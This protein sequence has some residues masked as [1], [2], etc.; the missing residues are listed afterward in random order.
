MFANLENSGIINAMASSISFDGSAA[1][2][3]S[4]DLIYDIS[5]IFINDYL[6]MMD[7]F[8]HSLM[9]KIDELPDSITTGEG[10]DIYT[11]FRDGFSKTFMDM[12]NDILYDPS[13]KASSY[14]V[15]T[16][17]ESSELYKDPSHWISCIAEDMREFGSKFMN[18][19][20]DE[21]HLVSQDII[22]EIH[23]GGCETDLGDIFKFID[24]AIDEIRKNAKDV[25]PN[26]FF[27][28]LVNNMKKEG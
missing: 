2:S 19:L 21:I 20:A 13:Y 1:E 27:M 3:S 28:S 15:L 4:R 9:E 22:K 23:E 24:E 6:Y 10:E 14:I 7:G 26:A 16:E 11:I 17:V 18:A 25:K 5:M 12:R 8:Y